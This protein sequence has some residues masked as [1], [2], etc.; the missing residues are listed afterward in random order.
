MNTIKKPEWLLYAHQVRVEPG[1]I[2]DTKSGKR[3]ERAAVNAYRSACN[4]MQYEGTFAD[5][6]FLV[7]LLPRR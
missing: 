7:G 4:E 2:K 3:T 1:N 6:S 5:W